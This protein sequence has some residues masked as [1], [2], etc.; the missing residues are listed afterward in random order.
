MLLLVVANLKVS[1]LTAVIQAAALR[2]SIVLYPGLHTFLEE[3][4]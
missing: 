1:F 4:V 2:L 3:G